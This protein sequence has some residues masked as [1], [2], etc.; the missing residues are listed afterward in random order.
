MGERPL[1]DRADGLAGMQR[2]AGLRRWCK[3]P[4]FLRIQRFRIDAAL[5]EPARLLRQRGQRVLQPVI[6]LPEQ[7]GT[8][9]GGQHLAGEFDLVAAPDAVRHLIDLY[10]CDFSAD[11]DDLAF[12]PGAVY[13]HIA[14]FVHGNIAVKFD[15]HQISVD[16]YDLSFAIFGHDTT[17][18]RS[19]LRME[20]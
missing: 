2:G 10:L 3:R 18:N 11:A 13:F 16:A 4:F 7:P 9:L 19:P 20:L 17:S 5:Q 1:R 15:G 8:E 12:Q 6:D 14:D